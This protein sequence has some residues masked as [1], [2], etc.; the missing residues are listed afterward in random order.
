MLRCVVRTHTLSRKCI[1]FDTSEYNVF[2]SDSL[3]FSPARRGDQVTRQF[4]VQCKL[5][6]VLIPF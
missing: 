6:S 5:S 4:S 1:I 3:H 2:L